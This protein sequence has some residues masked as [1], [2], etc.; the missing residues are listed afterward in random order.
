MNKLKATAA[1]AVFISNGFISAQAACQFPV[2]IKV[3]NGNYATE[4][5]MVAA[6]GEVKSYMANAE[7][8]LACIAEEAEASTA[9]MDEEQ[10][11]EQ[12]RIRDMRHNSAVDEMEK[13]AAEF[14]AQVR[15]FKKANQ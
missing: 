2:P 11:A 9:G 1:L 3:P 8:Y 6:Q 13:L 5:E 14:N 12:L 7:A 15:T 10:A 4:A